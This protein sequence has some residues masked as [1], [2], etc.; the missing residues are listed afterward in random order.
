MGVVY[1]DGDLTVT[2]GTLYTRNISARSGNFSDNAI[3]ITPPDG[4]WNITEDTG[5]IFDTYYVRG[6]ISVTGIIVGDVVPYLY[7][8]KFT[9]LDY[10]KGKNQI[11]YILNHIKDSEL[12]EEYKDLLY[13]Q[14]YASVISLMEHYLSCSFVGTICNHKESYH[15]VLRSGFLQKRFTRDKAVLNGPDC[16]DKELLFVELA[17]RIVFHN[18]KNVKELFEVAFGINVDLRPLEIQLNIRNDITHRFG[19]TDSILG[20]KVKI[21]YDDVKSLISAVDTIVHDT[22][23]QLPLL[24]SDISD[25]SIIDDLLG[26]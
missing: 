3:I 17:K 16:I 21:T 5:S 23:S 24:P 18:Q 22:Q 12:E 7:K 26:G 8:H 20:G 11:H 9:V 15:R 14:E 19:Y 1:V 10:E 2:T 25:L 4:V 13:Q 6:D